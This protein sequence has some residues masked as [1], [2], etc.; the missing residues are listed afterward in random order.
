MP[1]ILYGTSGQNP[2]MIVSLSSER[3]SRQI[4][5]ALTWLMP[6]YLESIPGD[7]L[8]DRSEPHSVVPLELS[9]VG[10]PSLVERVAS[11]LGL[12]GHISEPCRLAGEHLLAD[13]AVRI[14]VER[15]F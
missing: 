11:F 1:E 2:E 10:V 6:K 4:R 12:V 15:V 7:G 8:G 14:H 5:P 9:E 3:T 13:E